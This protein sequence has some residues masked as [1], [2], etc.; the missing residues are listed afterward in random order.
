M[1]P[2]V[3]SHEP[4]EQKWTYASLT[5]LDGPRRLKPAQVAFDRL[6][7]REPPHLTSNQVEIIL[8]NGDAEQRQM[9]IVLPHDDN[10]TRIPIRLLPIE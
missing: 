3:N 5:V 10:A 4:R 6:L 1:Q 7:F 2:S 8:T 9:A